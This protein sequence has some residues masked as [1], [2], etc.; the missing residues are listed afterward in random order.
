M[1]DLFDDVSELNAASEGGTDCSDAANAATCF[2]NENQTLLCVSQISL[3]LLV[4]FKSVLVVQ[5]QLSFFQFLE[6]RK[7]R[8]L[9]YLTK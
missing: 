6:I 3:Q 7:F 1:L 8:L 9:N 4:K 5:P 2:I